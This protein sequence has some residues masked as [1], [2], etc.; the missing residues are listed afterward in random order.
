M[1][2]KQ[3]APDCSNPVLR[4]IAIK[5]KASAGCKDRDDLCELRALFHAVK[6]GDPNV[7]GLENGLAYI[8]D[9][10]D[11]D[12][13][14]APSD[15]YNDC[16]DGACAADCDDHAAFVAALAANIGFQ[17][18]LRAWGESNSGGYQHVFAVALYPKEQSDWPDNGPLEYGLDTSADAGDEDEDGWQPPQGNVAT[19]W[20]QPA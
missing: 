16:L 6:Y 18:G 3:T 19:V 11:V 12:T 13:F 10:A 9:N 2:A 1:L 20:I 4:R 14:I 17:V 15:L 5:I 8:A 7:P